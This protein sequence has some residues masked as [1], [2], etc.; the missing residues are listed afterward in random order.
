MTTWNKYVTNDYRAYAE[1]MALAYLKKESQPVPHN[2]VAHLSRFIGDLYDEYSQDVRPIYVPG[3]EPYS[4]G[5]LTV[6]MMRSHVSQ[7][8]LLVADSVPEEMYTF[9][10][11]VNN[12]F[13]FVHDMIHHVGQGRGF[14]LGGEYGAF[15]DMQFRWHE[16]CEQNDR[17][18]L[19]IEQGDAILFSEMVLQIAASVYLGGYDKTRNGLSYTQKL[20]MVEGIF[21][22]ALEV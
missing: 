14:D 21:H 8:Y 18:S 7:G 15:L 1:M 4:Y 3:Y 9:S 5:Q 16:W 17:H 12:K 10:A 20:V 19:T 6:P 11:E 2:T 22:S 13:R